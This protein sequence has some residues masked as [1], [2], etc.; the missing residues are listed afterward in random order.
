MATSGTATFTLDVSEAVEEAASRA[1]VEIRSGFQW[2]GA[3]R[4]LNLLL[5]DFANRGLN[6]WTIDEGTIAITSGDGQYTLPSD[7]VDVL[8]LMF[9]PTG[10]TTDFY[11]ERIGVGSWAQIAVKSTPGRPIQAWVER[12]SDE[13]RM[14]LWPV[15]NAAG[16]MLYWRIRRVEDAGTAANNMD[17]PQRLLP[18]LISGLAYY[19]ALKKSPPDPNLV[20]FLKGLFEEDLMRAQLEDRGRESFFVGIYSGR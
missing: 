9:R 14:N 1:G 3:I 20:T 5:T 2:Q 16:S 12:L 18:A 15:P 19:L 4:S 17:V 11:V 13:V 10:S 7:T 6:L 8:N